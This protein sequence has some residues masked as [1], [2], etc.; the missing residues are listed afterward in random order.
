MSKGKQLI[1]ALVIGALALFGNKTYLESRVREL[2]PKKYLNVVRAKNRIRAGTRITNSMLQ[3]TRVPEKYLPKARVK[4]AEKDGLIGQ[5]LGVDVLKGDYLL[6]S[7]FTVGGTIGRTLSQ[8]LAGDKSRAINLSVDETNSLARSVVAGDRIDLIFSF[9]LP[10]VNQK[11]SITLLQN[12]LVLATGQYSQVEQE[13]GSKGGRPKRYNSLT[14]KVTPEDALRLNYAR[15]VGKINITLRN[16]QDA[17]LVTVPP[18][19]TIADILTPGDR[20]ELAKLVQRMESSKISNAERMKD[21]L[22]TLLE[23]QRQQKRGQ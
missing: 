22:S 18:I 17:D 20:E 16:V 13:L 2:S 9:S 15:Q 14:L 8:Q 10:F 23:L 21:Q 1:I 11:V 19:G 5:E 6:E 7:Y 4:W 12:V 3:A